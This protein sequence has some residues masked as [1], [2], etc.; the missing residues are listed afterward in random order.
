MA[1]RGDCEGYG[2]YTLSGGSIYIG[3]ASVASPPSAA[4]YAINL[5]GGTVGA[6]ATWASPLNMNLTGS[7]GPVTFNTAGNTITLS[8]ALSGSGG[9]TKVGAGTLELSGANSYTGDTTVNAGTLQLDAYRQ[10]TWLRC[11]LPTAR[12]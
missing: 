4:L 1:R 3:A 5:G 11:A 9:L 10:H 6:E 2:V 8:G 12:R 7:N